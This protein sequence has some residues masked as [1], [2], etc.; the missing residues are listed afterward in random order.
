MASLA[1]ADLC[2]SCKPFL[3]HLSMTVLNS[4]ANC[5]WNKTWLPL[6][7]YREAVRRGCPICTTTWNDQ[8]LHVQE[9]Y[10]EYENRSFEVWR[11]IYASEGKPEQLGCELYHWRGQGTDRLKSFDFRLVEHTRKCFIYSRVS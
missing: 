9:R 5:H 6:E 2:D 11:R 1:R 3:S 10:K 4:P 8:P 7:T